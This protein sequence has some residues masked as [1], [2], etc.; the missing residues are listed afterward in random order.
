MI[1]KLIKVGTVA[2][3]DRSDDE[4]YVDEDTVTVQDT[5][6]LKSVKSKKRQ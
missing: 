5:V 1:L 2:K 4:T 6:N 3:D